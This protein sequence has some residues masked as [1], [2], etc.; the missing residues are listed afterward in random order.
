[1][2]ISADTL[3][4]AARFLNLFSQ[5]PSSPLVRREPL[6]V[7]RFCS[8]PVH[9]HAR[10]GRSADWTDG[11]A[12]AT[13]AIRTHRWTSRRAPIIGTSLIVMAAGAISCRHDVF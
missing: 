3:E 11:V 8:G 2:A 7:M 13:T 9:S 4:R 5:Y 1:M 6:E 12:M 10:A